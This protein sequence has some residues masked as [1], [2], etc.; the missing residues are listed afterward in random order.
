MP[1][2]SAV[3]YPWSS[4]S[5]CRK[6]TKINT[7][8]LQ[9]STVA[10]CFVTCRQLEEVDRELEVHRETERV[11]HEK[12]INASSSLMPWLHVKLFQPSS[13]SV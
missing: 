11:L 5:L 7:T 3:K 13:T 9:L 6:V 10:K 1:K 4:C 12:V 8:V 2:F